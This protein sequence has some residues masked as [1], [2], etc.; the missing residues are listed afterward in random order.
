MGSGKNRYN[1][2][3]TE[4]INELVNCSIVENFQ[5][6]NLQSDEKGWGT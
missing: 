1:L 5:I 2:E 4:H 6:N 3:K